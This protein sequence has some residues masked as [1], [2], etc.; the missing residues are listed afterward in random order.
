VTDEFVVDFPTLGDVVDA[1]LK[2]HCR[3]PDGFRRGQP[4][5]QSD[6]QFWCTTNHYRVRPEAEWRPE[7]PLL[8]QAFTYRRSQ[9]VAPQK[10][11]K[12]PWGAGV[13]AAEAVGPVVFGGWAGKGDGYACSEHGCLCGWEYE[14]LPGEAM[15]IRHP[16]PLIQLTANSVDQVANVWRPLTAMIRLGPLSDLLLIREEFIRIV[17]QGGDD[18]ADRIDAVTSSARSRVGNPVSFVLQDETGLYT[19]QN[20]MIDVSEAQRRGAAGMGGRT[21]ETTN[22]WNPAEQS[23]AQRTF[24]STA[25][26]VFRFYRKPPEN[27]SYKNKRD[28]HKIH[29]YVYRGSPWV[30][31]DSIEAEA[32]EI[33]QSDP[34]Q[35][36]RFFG[37]RI[38]AGT[39]T[40]LPD[41]AWQDRILVRDRPVGE[42]VCLGFDGS[43]VDDWT[44]IRA[45]TFDMFQFTPADVLGRPTIWNPFETGGKV[46]RQDVLAAF[47]FIF[48]H[49]EV[50]RAYCD[51]PGWESQLSFLQGK[52]GD[53]RVVE[54]P[55]YRPAPMHAA[56]ERFRN[57]LTDPGMRF[58]HDMDK[59][60]E[61]HAA[62]AVM[63]PGVNQRY[64]LGKPSQSQKIDI[65][66]SSVLAHEAVAD[67]IAAGLDKPVET[68]ALF[69]RF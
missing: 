25:D 55:T 10:T 15:G 48:S 19:K 68:G 50:V 17:G 18:E 38:V 41:G 59:H 53:D 64:I 24:E 36:E 51:P 28:R 22:C 5:E 42:R 3:V 60:A 9:I 11:G 67:C 62:N 66:M 65:M 56:L 14:Y 2:Q 26:D 4:F 69:F 45:E 61:I 35:A 16:S 1:W 32:A 58:L 13:T 29:E 63:R 34:A 7:R 57:D 54:W 40:W 49:Y 47:D 30:D 31:L 20:K 33:M 52:Y 6:W 46:P 37:N 23:A 43:D 27:L 21:M 8:N 39:G 12:G 44:A